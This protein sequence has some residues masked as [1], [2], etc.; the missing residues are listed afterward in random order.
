M[1]KKTHEHRTLPNFY[2]VTSNR[3]CPSK[4]L[5]S[6]ITYLLS[7]KGNRA[8]LSTIKEAPLM[9]F[10]LNMCRNESPWIS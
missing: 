10:W 7:G 1:M 5:L 9:N 8:I 6:T 3:A 2:N 4:V